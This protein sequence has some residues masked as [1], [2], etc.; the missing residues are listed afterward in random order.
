MWCPPLQSQGCREL[1]VSGTFI[2][3]AQGQVIEEYFTA[4]I[5]EQYVYGLAY[6]NDLILRDR[7]ADSNMSTG[8]L[9]IS[10]SG[11]E[12]REYAEHD[13]QFSV[14]ALTNSSGTITERVA[15]DP[16]GSFTFLT[17]S[18]TAGSDGTNYWVVLYQGMR[19]LND[20]GVGNLFMSESRIY[21]APMGR[22]ISQDGGYWDGSN[23]YRAMDDN[24]AA[25]VDPDGTRP[26]GPMD[27]VD[28]FVNS[29]PA[30]SHGVDAG[31][32]NAQQI[33]NN[34]MQEL[35]NEAQNALQ[36]QIQK[37]E[38]LARALAQLASFGILRDKCP[39]PA[40]HRAAPFVFIA[41]TEG[42]GL[43]VEGLDGLSA[44]GDL[45]E[46]DDLGAGSGAGDV[47]GGGGGGGSGG[48]GGAGTGDLGPHAPGG[49]PDGY[50]V[51]K[52]G[53]TPPP[54]PG[55]LYSGSQGQ[56]LGEAGAGVPNGQVQGATAGEIRNNGGS[57]EVNPEFNNK[58]GATNYQHVDVTDGNL[59]SPM[60]PPQPNPVP[61]DQRFGFPNYPYGGPDYP[62]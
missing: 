58:V 3:S 4:G 62:Y 10:G 2:S 55:T 37:Q 35:Q 46:G 7:N 15:Y 54:E 38:A 14:I 8:N 57:V 32:A 43:I 21:D 50:T 11:L 5:Y 27:F 20:A 13:K 52:G 45:A 40:A 30:Y 16:Y 9:G 56:N 53:T 26:R 28:D 25:M 47:G 39:D 42:Y 41:L 34:N 22:W 19:L 12:E 49:V 48:G 36:N 6:V 59:G 29:N 17:P 61:K 44:L 23:L 60:G 24:P 51:V 31:Q 1:K 33:W 18:W